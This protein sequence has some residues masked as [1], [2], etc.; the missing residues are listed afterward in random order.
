MCHSRPDRESSPLVS[1]PRKPKVLCFGRITSKQMYGNPDLK[2]CRSGLRRANGNP[3]FRNTNIWSAGKFLVYRVILQLKD[4]RPTP[5]TRGKCNDR[6]D[7]RRFRSVILEPFCHSWALKR[8]T[9]DRSCNVPTWSGI[10]SA[11]VIPAK[12]EGTLL[13]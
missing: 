8:N 12:A 6:G 9:Y 1:F 5:W 3:D 7:Y 10:Q 2:H 4:K 13:R 11:C